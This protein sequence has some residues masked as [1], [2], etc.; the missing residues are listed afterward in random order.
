MRGPGKGTDILHNADC[1]LS[2]SDKLILR[3]LNLSTGLLTQTVQITTSS[4]L[5][6][7]LDRIQHKPG[8]LNVL[9][10]LGR[11][12]QVGVERRVPT[13]QEP[14]LDLSILRQTGLA[15]LL[16][17]QGVFL[18]RVRQGV[19]TGSTLGQSLR[20]S[21]GGAGNGVVEGLGLG[22]RGRRG[23]QGSLGL[24]GRRGLGEKLN[25]LVDGASQ[26]IEG[27]AN[28]RG[29]IVGFVGVLGAGGGGKQSIGYNHVKVRNQLKSITVSIIRGTNSRHLQ[30]LLV[31]D[32]QGIHTLLKLNVFLG[33]LS[34]V[35]Y[36]A[37]LL[38]NHLLGA[39]SKRR[40]I[41]ASPKSN[42]ED[43]NM[44][45]GE[46]FFIVSKKEGCGTMR[47]RIPAIRGIRGEEEA[48]GAQW[49]FLT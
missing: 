10:R 43:R 16:R 28:I 27:F 8:I 31:D 34:L 41:R 11:K 1:F 18:Q 36:L 48:G 5:L 45:A 30:Q 44:S 3:L 4:R 42:A 9:T 23:S 33:E 40:E 15:H 35:L 19:F 12:H 26:V 39:S 17:S 24:C 13:S 14:R 22:L 32:L 25:L 37:K 7:S 2:L 6:A 38:L 29:I 20:S 21:Q 46:T 47:R 49:A